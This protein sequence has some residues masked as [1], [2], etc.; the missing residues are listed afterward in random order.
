MPDK[1][2]DA[3][4]A[5]QDAQDNLAQK[6]SALALIAQHAS[7]EVAQRQIVSK[8]GVRSV[9]AFLADQ[10]EAVCQHAAMILGHLSVSQTYRVEIAG[11]VS[12]VVPLLASQNLVLR[13]QAIAMLGRLLVHPESKAKLATR[14]MLRAI[15][16]LLQDQDP[17]V[18]RCLMPILLSESIEDVD[19]ILVEEGAI[20]PLLGLLVKND[21]RTRMRN[22]LIVLR[23]IR[24][25]EHR[26]TLVQAGVVDLLLPWVACQEPSVRALVVSAL[27][28]LSVH[29]D[30]QSI[31]FN[32]SMMPTWIR[33]MTHDTRAI[34]QDLIAITYHASWRPDL[35]FVLLKHMTAPFLRSMLLD[36]DGA[37]CL[38]TLGLLINCTQ[39]KEA[40]RMMIEG[41]LMPIFISLLANGYAAIQRDA[42]VLIAS[43]CDEEGIPGSLGEYELALCLKV[44]PEGDMIRCK[45]ILRIFSC[46]ITYELKNKTDPKETSRFSRFMTDDPARIH[47]LLAL[48]SR[49]EPFASM[50]CW[51][52]SHLLTPDEVSAY[53][54]RGGEPQKAR[55]ETVEAALAHSAVESGAP[56][57]AFSEGRAMSR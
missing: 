17:E 12:W 49:G 38:D 52:L 15:V 27:C 16:P 43:L 55:P 21:H 6:Q 33:M 5:L 10:D 19:S 42:A 24:T 50:V 29:H 30:A 3:L 31:I 4:K 22:L 26:A 25:R 36:E 18:Q 53:L 34:R 28:R 8:L 7:D 32:A 57:E 51:L 35:R 37:M 40:R 56:E 45:N 54:T 11:F 9:C 14:E 2:A 46:I 20:M 48:V 41:A 47:T 44:L 13:C 39:S 23:C 1:I